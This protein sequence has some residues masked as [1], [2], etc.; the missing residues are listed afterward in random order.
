LE[1]TSNLA[2]RAGRWS[3]RHR[4]TAIIGWLVFVVLAVM[5]GGSV[6]TESIEDEDQGVGET[7]DADHATLRAFRAGGPMRTEMP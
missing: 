6:G 5:V 1:G 4:A 3:A 7:R 2:A